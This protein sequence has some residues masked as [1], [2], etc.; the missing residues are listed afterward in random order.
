MDDTKTIII[1]AVA[2]GMSA[3]SKLRR[4]DQNA[5]IHVY[6]KGTDISYGACGMPYYIGGIIENERSLIAR[7]KDEFEKSNIRVF[8]NHEAITVDPESK[9][10]TLLNSETNEIL[11]DQ[12]DKLLIATGASARKTYVSG[13]NLPNI[14]VLSQLT[15]ARKL[16]EL[17]KNAKTVVMIG[18]GYIGL[19]IAENLI[20]LGLKVHII[21]MMN[22][23]LPVYDF[24]FAKIAQ[25]E[26]EQVGV[27]VH[28]NESLQSYEQDND[29]II[30]NTDKGSYQG[31]L[32]IEA[33]GVVPN[34]IFLKE[35]G[36]ETLKNGAIVVNERMET[37][38]RDIYAAGDCAAYY[39]RIKK[40]LAY[41]PLGTHANKTGRVVAENIAGLDSKFDG[42]IGSSIL[43]V[44]DLAVAKT[45]VGFEEAKRLGLDYDYVDVDTKNHAGYYP[46]Y[47]NIYIRIIYERGTG[48]LKGAEMV[49]EA[50]VSDRINVMAVAVSQGMSAQEFSQLDLAY[51][52]PYNSVWDPLQVATNIIKV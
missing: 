16:K 21:E 17:V 7:T 45:G 3:A 13:R 4:L 48:I 30:V 44:H 51:S 19:E 5:I 12:Y 43:K 47:K 20:H 23:L 52:P 11:T 18:G 8:L 24:D 26:L 2:A 50:G 33:I 10:V 37:S 15:D 40:E 46:G 9:T 36:M 1:G 31:D 25:V 14:H 28:L 29:T 49:G 34:T 32:V 27:Q 42:I 22:Q 6:E 35:T 41:V 39:H 38:I